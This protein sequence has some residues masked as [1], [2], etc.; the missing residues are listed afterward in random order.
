MSRIQPHSSPLAHSLAVKP[1]TVQSTAQ[2][3]SSS[4][5]LP[6]DQMTV[7]SPQSSDIPSPLSLS[8]P[9][10]DPLQLSTQSAAEFILGLG[11]WG[12]GSAA[13]E[14]KFSL[15]YSPRE[16]RE[17]IQQFQTQIGAEATGLWNE[18]TFVKAKTFLM[19][20]F[21]AEE[22]LTDK[23]FGAFIQ[24]VQHYYQGALDRDQVN[25]NLEA[26]VYDLRQY[27]LHT[28]P[29]PDTVGF[30]AFQKQLDPTTLMQLS[31][32]LAE[33]EPDEIQTLTQLMQGRLSAEQNAQTLEAYFLPEQLE[34]IDLQK[35]ATEQ[36][37]AMVFQEV[38]SGLLDMPLSEQSG[39]FDQATY[40][41]FQ[42]FLKQDYDLDMSSE[43]LREL[44]QQTLHNFIE[45]GQGKLSL[46]ALYE[47]LEP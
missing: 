25:E 31:L 2:A 42:Q 38:Q 35:P 40:D 20:E 14:G 6:G 36:I 32:A 24:D 33:L 27:P 46:D 23:Q 26:Y 41:A 8:A 39:L 1:S 44:T 47:A 4:A 19:Q 43:A 22:T 30:Q 34:G 10:T 21:D 37:Q 9:G 12:Y 45:V 16:H 11:V 3:T 15:E 5:R 28:P 29:Q 18:E 7:S 13:D 17:R